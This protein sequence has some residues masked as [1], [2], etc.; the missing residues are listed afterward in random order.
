M[1]TKIL[2][3]MFMLIGGIIGLLIVR[4]FFLNPVQIAGWKM[5]WGSF[6]DAGLISI[7]TALS[8]KTFVK[9]A[10]GFVIGAVVG[11]YG[12]IAIYLKIRNI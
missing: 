4:N 1:K 8:S 7:D 11:S 12:G 5:F 2:F 9:S 6:P 10:L 3:F